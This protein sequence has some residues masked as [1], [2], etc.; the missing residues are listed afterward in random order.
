MKGAGVSPTKQ[1]YA[2]QFLKVAILFNDNI[3]PVENT[4][5]RLNVY[6]VQCISS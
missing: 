6:Y 4:A 2:S 5:T 1:I 3:I